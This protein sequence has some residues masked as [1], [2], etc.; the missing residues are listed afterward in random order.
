MTRIK[1]ESLPKIMVTCA[2]CGYRGEVP[3][4]YEW[5]SGKSGVPPQIYLCDLHHFHAKS[6]VKND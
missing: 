4:F 2:I 6:R 5:Y 3:M 1:G